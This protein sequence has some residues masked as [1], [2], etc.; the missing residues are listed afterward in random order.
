MNQPAERLLRTLGSIDATADSRTTAPLAV[1][2]TIGSYSGAVRSWSLVAMV[3]D[4]SG[5][6]NTPS[7]PAALVLAMAVRTAS[8]SSPIEASASGLTRTRMAGCSAPLTLTSATPSTCD[9]R[10]AITVSA[11]S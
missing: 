5:P 10:C 7:A 11:A 3:T 1:R 4:R 6:S 8:M 9:S 2:T